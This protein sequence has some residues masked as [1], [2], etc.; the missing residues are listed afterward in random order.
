MAGLIKKAKRGKFRPCRI[1][2]A[3]KRPRKQDSQTSTPIAPCSAQPTPVDTAL[4]PTY[5]RANSH[6]LAAPSWATPSL[7]VPPAHAA[8][9]QKLHAMSKPSQT[10]HGSCAC[11]RNRYVVEIPATESQ[12]AELRYD[13]TAASRKLRIPPFQPRTSTQHPLFRH[14]HHVI[15]PT[16][17]PH[18]LTPSHPNPAAQN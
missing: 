7:R 6:P 18:S 5:T 11:G 4:P 12:L 10:L 14:Q 9:T 1:L 13:N 17:P 2:T 15:Y 8:H 16:P 3:R